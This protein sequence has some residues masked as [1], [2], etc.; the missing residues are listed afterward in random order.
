MHS[1]RLSPVTAP[2]LVIT[3]VCLQKLHRVDEF[4]P[5]VSVLGAHVDV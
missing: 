1:L 5:V 4:L 2:V 3:R